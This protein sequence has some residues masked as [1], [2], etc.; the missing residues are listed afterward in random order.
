M[1]QPT[2][3]WYRPEIPRRELKRFMARGDAKGLVNF[4]LWLACLAG[5]GYLAYRAVGSYW[6]ILAFF[7]YGT[8]Y[9][10]CDARWHECAHGTPFRTRWLNETFYL[11][12]SIM[13]MKEGTYMR[14][15]HTR[16]HTETIMVGLDPEIQVMRP[17]D[18]RRVVLDFFWIP[19]AVQM[20]KA[21]ISHALGRP[22]KE[23]RDFVPQSEW[24]KMFFWSRFY[25]ALYALM[26]VWAIAIR[27]WLPILFFPLARFY[28]GWLHQIFSL[29]QH[30]GLAEN[31]RDHR[32]NTRTVQMNPVFRFLYFN[33]NYHIEHH[34]FPT[35]PFHALPDLHDR[36]EG[37]LPHTYSGLI[38]AFREIIPTLLK[39]SKDKDYFVLREIPQSQPHSE[40]SK[41]EGRVMT[42]DGGDYA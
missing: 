21:M 9:S 28:G 24:G 3:D 34:M 38:A 35:V 15:S 1:A 40:V 18:L 16:H 26:I 31:V 10:S 36:I 2:D 20:F 19:D 11:L 30:A 42:V 12:S 22:T 39:Q 5:S 25:L 7:L 17:A 41:A 13:N 8:I 23:A 14:W 32:L 4:G 27:S 29:T 33:M 37:V 6:V